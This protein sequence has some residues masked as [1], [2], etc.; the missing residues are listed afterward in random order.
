MTQSVF[1]LKEPTEGMGEEQKKKPGTAERLGRVIYRLGCVLGVLSIP[2]A[3]LLLPL[4]PR[5]DPGTVLFRAVVALLIG[6][7][8]WLLGRAAR[9]IL[10]GD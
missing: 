10:K 7:G 9:N 6:L 5:D 1:P 3:V 8:C 2:V 4:V